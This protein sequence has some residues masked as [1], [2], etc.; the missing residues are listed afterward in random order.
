MNPT[1]GKGAEMSDYVEIELHGGS[2]YIQPKDQL[3]QAIDGELQEIEWHEE[4][5]LTFRHVEMTDEEY[6]KLPEFTGH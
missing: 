5:T 1:S 3:V 6:A 2:K 4:I